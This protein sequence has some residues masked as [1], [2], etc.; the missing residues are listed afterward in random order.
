MFGRLAR[1]AGL[2]EI[3]L[4]N[5]RHTFGTIAYEATRDPKQVQVWMGHSLIG[6]T[7]NLYV[8]SRPDAADAAAGQVAAYLGRRMTAP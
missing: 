1:K 8:H 7:L 3:R 4:H 6:T 5:A 2:P